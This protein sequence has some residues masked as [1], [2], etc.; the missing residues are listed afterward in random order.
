MTHSERPTLRIRT[1]DDLV[2][3]IPRLLGFQPHESLTLVVI[4][5][6]SLQVTAR[7]DL[8]ACSGPGLAR[9]FGP[10]WARHPA[11]LF[12]VVAYSADE[13]SAWVALDAFADAAPATLEL[14]RFHADGT[15]WSE[16]WGAPG[17]PYDP[18]TNVAAVAA[19]YEG[20]AVLPDREAVVAS[21][22]P[23][24]T[25]R[26]VRR[27]L[28]AVERRGLD[29]DG[30]VGAALALVEAADAGQTAVG[31]EEVAILALASYDLAFREA[32]ILSTSRANAT[33]RIE[34]WRTVVRGTVPSCAG[35]ALVVLGLAAWVAG[36][37]ALQ[38]VCL[39]RA[40]SLATDRSWLDFLSHVNT[41][42]VPPSEWEQ[43]RADW[44]CQHLE[45]VLAS[46]QRQAG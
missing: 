23:A 13:T 2:A 8:A 40:Q 41:L 12:L 44:Y 11:A 9:Q 42:V 28:R 19:A 18:S 43:L 35:F 45:P 46:P 21:L 7:V 25:P 3:V 39:E 36:Q 22:D 37:G 14:R 29:H 38:V 32:A 31:L 24:A 1:V 5:E 20:L 10:L 6:G 16:A 15:R 17:Q 33:A 34:L 30:L 27:A 26:Q 4:E